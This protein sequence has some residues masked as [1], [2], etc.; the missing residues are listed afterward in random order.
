MG[1]VE[2]GEEFDDLSPDDMREMIGHSTFYMQRNF[3]YSNELLQKVG[4]H[5]SEIMNTYNQGDLYEHEK[6]LNSDL[7][8]SYFNMSVSIA[9]ELND[10]EKRNE[11]MDEIL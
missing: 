7:F 4:R 2:A 3:D 1:A 8:Q 6:K 5:Y 9:G 11:E 10:L